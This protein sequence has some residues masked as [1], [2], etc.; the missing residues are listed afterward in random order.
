MIHVIPCGENRRVPAL[1]SADP[2]AS[3]HGEQE[4]G[5]NGAEKRWKWSSAWEPNS[6]A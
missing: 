2:L 1:V 5:N 3:I 4:A 6:Q